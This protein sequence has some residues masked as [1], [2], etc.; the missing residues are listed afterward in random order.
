MTTIR[1]L[2]QRAF[3]ETNLLRVGEETPANMEEEA[4]VE[5]NVLMSSLFGMELGEHLPSVP[6]G[7]NNVDPTFADIRNDTLIDDTYVPSNSRLILNLESAKTINLN[8]CPAE[9]ERFAIVDAS[10]NLAT[11]NLTIN[12]NGRKV[13][14][15]SS[16]V[17][18]TNNLA[19]EWFY[20]AD[21]ATWT[22]LTGLVH[23]SDFPLPAEFELFITI[24][25]AIRL[26][27]RYGQT[28]T[29]D[30][31]ETLRR[32]RRMFVTRFSQKK[33]MS[34][35]EGLLRLPSNLRYYEFPG[36]YFY[37]GRII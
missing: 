24:L 14:T 17:L 18:N 32:A 29:P 19:R 34:V 37:L 2:I 12:G 25:L 31:V 20:R 26:N 3:R 28:L 1:D 27:P 8:P 33:Q 36:S 16:L 9:G 4:I 10:G 7:Q 11:Y 6:Y 23:S 13:E 15:A 30:L 35:D 21:T 5:L 22:R